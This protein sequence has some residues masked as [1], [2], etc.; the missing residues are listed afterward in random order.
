MK[1]LLIAALLGISANVCAQQPIYATITGGDLYSFD[2]ANC[3]RKL[4]GSTGVGFGDIAFTADGKLWGIAGGELFEIN[5]A[6]AAVRSLGLTGVQAV[7]LVGLNDT[8]LLA[9]DQKKLYSINVKTGASKYIDT[10]GFQAA[11]DLTWYD[12]DLVMVTSDGQ[13]VKITLNNSNTA[14]L[15]VRPA[16]SYIPTCEGA[17]TASFKD[18]YNAIVGFSGKDAIKICPVDGSYKMLC[19]DLNIGGTPGAASMRLYTQF[20]KPTV[21]TRPTAIDEQITGKELSL[22]PM[23]PGN[24][25]RLSL[26][27][28]AGICI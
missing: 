6:T 24:G 4:I 3:T 12:T 28:T 15:S 27:E 11:G 2:L 21:C 26:N 20:P 25:L 8:L 22:F 23:P 14:V 7:S 17:V 19:P 9:E 5:T 1:K 13:I 10:I 16:G 18:D